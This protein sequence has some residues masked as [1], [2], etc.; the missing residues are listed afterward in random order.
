M[1]L[2]FWIALLVGG[3]FVGGLSAGQ[4]M[5]FSTEESFRMK[6]VARD[7]LFGAFLSSMVY[8]LM[9]ETV[10]GLVEK[11][12]ETLQSAASVVQKGGLPSTDI[13][14]HVGPARF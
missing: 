1:E 13:D 2:G 5:F 4:Q 9:P 11:G 12:Q 10:L 14:L 3:L 7:F 8:Y 6:P